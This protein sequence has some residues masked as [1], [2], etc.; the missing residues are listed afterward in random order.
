MIGFTI[1]VILYALGAYLNFEVSRLAAQEF[2]GS[3]NYVYQSLAWPWVVLQDIYF[4][5]KD[6]R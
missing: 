2:K 3:V 6:R 1:A 5:F 4:D